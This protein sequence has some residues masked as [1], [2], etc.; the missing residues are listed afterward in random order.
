MYIVM[1]IK[2]NKNTGCVAFAGCKPP[3]DI[4]HVKRLTQITPE[5]GLKD[6]LVRLGCN[7]AT[8]HTYGC[9]IESPQGLAV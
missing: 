3:H 7:L 1:T 8:Q 4:T 2:P 5:V 9:F 6:P